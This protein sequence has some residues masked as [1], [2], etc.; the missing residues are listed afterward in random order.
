MYLVPLKT[1]LTDAMRRTFADPDY[2]SVDFRGLFVSIEFPDKPQAYPGIWVD[3]EPTSVNIIGVDHRETIDSEAYPGLKSEFTRWAFKGSVT[4]TAV[5]FSSLERDR[6]HDEVLAAI[7]FGK[8]NAA[9][10]TLRT[11]LESNEFVALDCDWDTVTTGGMSA[12][13]G[14]P[15]GTDDIIYEATLSLRVVGDF[16]S[17]A[18]ESGVALLPLSAIIV[19]PRV[20]GSPDAPGG[21]GWV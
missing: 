10:S 8:E 20:A 13:Q 1:T 18:D 11:V 16:V 19:H 6:L 5:A 17:G 9:R 15:W 7:A 21:A 12:Q 4:Y 3:Y 14:T 2:P